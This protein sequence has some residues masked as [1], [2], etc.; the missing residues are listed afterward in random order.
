MKIKAW[1]FI[2]ILSLFMNASVLATVGYHY[3]RNTCLTPS[4]PCPL[5]G[6]NHHLYQSLGLS[7]AQ[8][9]QM[10]PLSKTFH[11]RIETLGATMEGKR[12][13]LIDLLEHE[14]SDLSS[15][16]ETRKEI[17]GI[18]DTIQKEVMMHIMQTKKILNP[19]Q[20]KRFFE[21]LRGSLT[22]AR[23]SSAFPISGGNK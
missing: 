1:V 23:Q 15:I 5:N 2:L 12:N 21:L 17:A 20:Q 6:G 11:A 14:G 18:Q 4:A 19:Q 16:E 3:Y 13:L 10:E 7:H 22:S 9:A 8:L